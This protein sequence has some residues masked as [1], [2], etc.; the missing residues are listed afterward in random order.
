MRWVVLG[1]VT[2]IYFIGIG[3]IGMSGMAELLINLGYTISGSDLVNSNRTNHLSNIGVNVKIGHLEENI[4]DVDLVVY[5]SA[6]NNENVELAEARKIQLPIV[7]RAEMLGE[8]LKLKNTSIAVSGTHGKTS[9]TSM[10]GSI[11]T[12]A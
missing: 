9:T 10:M 4:K 3:G 6:I 1:K 11:L 5:S 2:S 7:R 12:E 8:L